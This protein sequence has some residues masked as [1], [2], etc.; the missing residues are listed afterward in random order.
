MIARRSLLGTSLAAIAVGTGARSAGAQDRYPS[1]PIR[2]VIPFPPGGG[3][4]AV[5]RPLGPLMTETLGQPI[6]LDNR[7]GANGNLG[8][9]IVAK[10]PADGY[11]LLLAN[12]SLTISGGLYAKLPFNPLADFSPISLV[13]VTPSVL[14]THP[15]LPARTVKEFV[16][17]AKARPGKLSYGSSG[18]GSTMHLGAALLQSMAGLDTVHVPYKGGGPAIADA[19]SGQTD[20]IFVNPVAVLAQVR[21]GK[22]N[23]LAVTS[24]KRLAILPD[25]PTFEEVGYPGL[26]S[27]TFY[28]LLGPAGLPRE[29]VMRLNAAVVAAVARKELADHLV[30]LG[31]EMESNTPE[32]FAAFLRDDA[33]QWLRLIKMT[34][35]SAE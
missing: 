17:L 16:E 11:T 30:A 29:I 24:K 13:G 27:S 28:G 7:G 8:A 25:V 33:A 5:A 6:V 4:D 12:S 34:G 21:A 32:Q 20:F 26:L 3:A 19:L 35:A 10:A 15:S 18:I 31:Y 23:A 2:L 14:A 1:K 9:E 22:L